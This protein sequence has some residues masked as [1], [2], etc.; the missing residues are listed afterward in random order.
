MDAF[1][2]QQ[3]ELL[4]KKNNQPV[5]S[6]G[7][8]VQGV[9]DNNQQPQ[10]YIAPWATPQ[11]AQPEQTDGG[12]VDAA[13]RG[14]KN[15]VLGT[16]GDQGKAFSYIA[17]TDGDIAQS[18]L[19]KAAQYGNGKTEEEQYTLE[20]RLMPWKN[21]FQYYTD[22]NGFIYEIANLGGSMATLAAESLIPIPGTGLMG[23]VVGKAV[24]NAVKS[25]AGKVIPATEA[26]NLAERAIIQN[27]KS[28]PLEILAN[29]GGAGDQWVEEHG[30]NREG[31]RQAVI[32]EALA[33]V[34]AALVDTALEV[35]G[36]LQ[37]LRGG[38]TG[39][40]AMGIA[41]SAIG[42]AYEEGYQNRA[43]KFAND[44]SSLLGVYDPTQWDADDWNAA[45]VGAMAGIPT[46][47]GAAGGY[48]NDRYRKRNS[49]QTPQENQEN[50]QA[51]QDTQQ[52]GYRPAIIAEGIE[53]ANLQNTI[54]EAVN[55][56]NALNQFAYDTF[57]KD[58]IVS[59]G[60]RSREHNAEVNGH[61]NSAHLYG[62]ALDLDLSNFTDEER[63]AIEERAQNLGFK[64]LYHDAGSGDH[65]HLEL[66]DGAVIN[67]KG[68][69]YTNPMQNSSLEG[70]ENAIEGDYVDEHLNALEQG[71]ALDTST[72]AGLNPTTQDL[73]E[74]LQ[75]SEQNPEAQDEL[76]GQVEEARK[77]YEKARQELLVAGRL[78]KAQN[79]PALKKEAA[80]KFSEIKAKYENLQNL[81]KNRYNTRYAPK[82]K[83][84]NKSTYQAP[85]ENQAAMPEFSGEYAR[86]IPNM[87][88][89]ELF[90]FAR[91]NPQLREQTTMEMRKRGL[92]DSNFNRAGELAPLGNRSV[93]RA[94]NMVEAEQEQEP[95]EYAGSNRAYMT[96]VN[97]SVD[98]RAGR[99]AANR[100]ERNPGGT[101]A[102]YPTQRLT[103]TQGIEEYQFQPEESA[104]NTRITNMVERRRQE[105]AA[106][107]NQITDGKAEYNPD[108]PSRF[109]DKGSS[110]RSK[111]DADRVAGI[112]DAEIVNDVKAAETKALK[113]G[114]SKATIGNIKRDPNKLLQLESKA[115]GGNENAAKAIA[116][117]KTEAIELAYAVKNGKGVAENEKSRTYDNQARED[118]KNQNSE[119]EQTEGNQGQGSESTENETDKVA[120]L[121]DGY[122]TQ[123][124]RD[125]QNADRDEFIVRPDGSLKFG[126]IT[127]EI[128]DLTN[129]ELEPGEIRVRVG[130]EAQGMIHA[131]KHESQIKDAG[132]NTAEE[133][134]EDT[135]KNIDEIYRRDPKPPKKKI[136][137]TV[138]NRKSDKNG[139]VSIGLALEK[140]E[141]GNY[142]AVI[143]A[144]PKTEK[145]LEK[146]I[147]KE[148]LVYRS[149]AIG[150][151]TTPNGSAVSD[152]AQNDVGLEQNRLPTSGISNVSKGSI[153]QAEEKSNN[154]KAF[155][156]SEKGT[157]EENQVVKPDVPYTFD[158]KTFNGKVKTEAVLVR[159]EGKPN[160]ETRTAMKAVGI[161]WNPKEK[162]WWTNV[163]N[164]K[165]MELV[166][167]W[168]YGKEE[169]K[170]N[171]DN[172]VR[173]DKFEEAVEALT[174]KVIEDE[175]KNGN[176]GLSEEKI[177]E[178]AKEL[179]PD[180]YN[181]E[182][183]ETM[184][185]E[186]M[187]KAEKDIAAN[188]EGVVEYKAETTNKE[189]ENNDAYSGNLQD[190]SG[191]QVSRVVQG[192]EGERNTGRVRGE[193][194]GRD[195]R[196]IQPGT[197]R[198]DAGEPGSGGRPSGEGKTGERTSGNGE[199]SSDSVSVR[200]GLNPEQKKNAKAKEHPGHNC[201]ISQEVIDGVKGEGFQAKTRFKNN[202]AAIR[203]IHKLETENR[204]ATPAEQ[205]VLAKYIGWGGLSEAFSKWT[206]DWQT[207]YKELQDMLQEGIITKEE[208]SSM[209]RSTTSAFYTPYGVVKG[210]W[211]M[212]ERFGFKGG[213]VLEPSMGTGNF[214]GIMPEKLRSKSSLQGVEYDKFTG[215]IAKQ[216]YQKANIEIAG[217][218]DVHN[219]ENF[220]DLIISNVP[221][222]EGKPRD[223]KYNKE[224]L[225]IHN[226]FF[227]KSVELTR[228]GGLIVF[229]TST[230]TMG[231]NGKQLRKL[232]GNKVDFIGAIRLPDNTFKGNAGTSVTSDLVIL[233]KREPNSAAGKNNNAWLEMVG[234]GVKVGWQEREAPI[235][236]YFKEHPEMLI[237]ETVSDRYG[238]GIV[239]S[240]KDKN[241]NELDPA[242]ELAAR[243][244]KLPANIY[245]PVKATTNTN[246]KEATETYLA[247]SKD[248][249]GSYKVKNG[250]VYTKTV[251]NK[252]VPLEERKQK[253]ALAYIGLRDIAK[254][255]LGA[256]IS[257]KTTDAELE[258]MRKELNKAYDDFVDK[259]GYLH[260]ST[261]QN[262][263]AQ[264]PEFGLIRGIERYD[265]V[266]E[267]NKV[268]SATAE[269]GA[270]FTQR[271]V[272]AL[273]T[274][275]KVDNV[276]DGLSV[277]LGQ[278][279]LVDIAY[280]SKLTGKSKA[281]V[282][283]ELKG[284]IYQDPVTQDYVTK[285]DYLSGNVR[286]KLEN[287]K[288]ANALE[289]K[290]KEN[291][292][293]LEKVVPKNLTKDDITVSLGSIWVPPSDFKDFAA[294]MLGCMPNN[295]DIQYN[296]A[297]GW[298]VALDDPYGR[299]KYSTANTDKWG[300]A[301][302][303][304]E[305]NTLN[306]K[307]FVDLLE[308][309]LNKKPTPKI[310]ISGSEGAVSKSGTLA[311]TG[312]IEEIK[313][314]FDNWIWSS[315]ERTERL[316]NYYNNHFNSYVPRVY[317]GD[318]LLAHLTDHGYSTA[319]PILRPHQ[320]DAVW[321]I[322]QGNTLLAHSVGAGKTWTMQTAAMEMKRLGIARKPMFVIPGHMLQQFENEFR[323]IYPNARLLSISTDT[324]PDV[325]GKMTAEKR[326]EKNALRQE[327]LSRIATED[328]DGIIISHDMFKRI[329]MSP[330][331]YAAFYQEEL[332]ELE[333]A[334]IAANADRQNKK[335]NI[336]KDLQAKKE[337]LEEKLKAS[338]NVEA[339]DI[340]IPFESLGIDQ[341]FVDEADLFKNLHFTTMMGNVS[342]LANS[343]AQRSTDMY[344]KTRYLTKNNSGRGVCFATGT[345]VS[346]SLA[347]EFTMLR[348]L[349][350]DRLQ[351]MGLQ[352]FDA[353]A[354]AFTKQVETAEVNP[355]GSGFRVV[356]KLKFSNGGD[357][358]RLFRSVADVK[359]P[360]DL[361]LKVPKLKNG[362]RTVVELP[363]NSAYDDF[364][365]KEIW[366]RAEAIRENKVEPEEDNMLKITS[367]QRL[368]S[369]DMRLVKPDLKSEDADAK[370]QAVADRVYQKF[371]DSNDIK[372]AQLVFCDLSTPK[373][374]SDKVT[375]TDAADEAEGKD[376]IV[377]Y[378]QILKKLV[379]KGI[380]KKQIAFAHDAKTKAQKEALFS[381]VR[382]GDIR[383]LIGSTTKMG[384]GTNC[385]Q[386]LVA[387]HH[388]DAPWRPRD[389][390]QR[391][392]R[393]LRQGNMNDEVE[394]FTYVTKGSF[395]ESMWGRIAYKSEVIE[396]ALSDDYSIREFDDI[397]PETLSYADIQA[398]ASGNPL[399][400]QQTIVN[401]EVT[402]LLNMK[403]AYENTQ[404]LQRR[405]IAELP[406]RIQ[407]YTEL[408]KIANDDV[409]STVNV[410]GDN[411]K[412]ELAGET[413]T[414]L[415]DA[416]EA[417]EK[418]AEGF[419]ETNFIPMG[420]I[421]HYS[422]EVKNIGKEYIGENNFKNKVEVKLVGK[423]VY[424]AEPSAQSIKYRAMHA[425]DN[426]A[427][428]YGRELEDNLK[429]LQDLQE[430]LK[431]P[432]PQ[433][434]ELDNKLELQQK[435]AAEIEAQTVDKNINKA[436]EPKEEYFNKALKKYPGIANSELIRKKFHDAIM[437]TM[438]IRA[439]SI[440]LATE[441]VESR[442]HEHPRLS[443]TLASGVTQEL[444]NE[445]T[446]SL[447]GKKI[448]SV[449]ELAEY[450]QVLRHP[451][452][453]K[454]HRIYVDKNGT[455]IDHDTVTSMMP[456]EVS[457]YKQ[458]ERG[459]TLQ[460]EML[461]KQKADRPEVAKVYYIHNHPST[462]TDPSEMD[463]QLTYKL[464]DAL[465]DKF[466]GHI[467]LD[468][469]KYAHIGYDKK[470]GM[471][472]SSEHR[473]PK[474][475][476]INYFAYPS[477]GSMN[478]VGK[479]IDGWAYTPT[480]AAWANKMDKEEGDVVAFLDSKYV[481]RAVVKLPT[482]INKLSAPA[483]NRYLRALARKNY[484]ATAIPITTSPEM[485][486]KYKTMVRLGSGLVDAMLVPPLKA[487]GSFDLS[488]KMKSAAFEAEE[489]PAKR[490]FFGR[491]SETKG[492]ANEAA[493][494]YPATRTPAMGDIFNNAEE[495]TL[496]GNIAKE[497]GV[498]GWLK[499][500]WKEVYIDWFDKN[501][502]LHALDMAIESGL[503]RKLNESEKV[504]NRNQTLPANTAG[505]AETLIEGSDAQITALNDALELKGTD[506]LSLVSMQKVLQTISKQVMD[507]VAPTFL[508]DNHFKN[509]VDAFGAYLG[510][511]RL[512][513]MYDV[514]KS[515]GVEYKLPKG[516]TEKQLRDFVKS[517]PKEFQAAATQYYLINRNLLKIMKQSGLISKEN[518]D[519]LTT[520]YKKYCPLMRDFTD[521]A[522]ADAFIGGLSNGGRGIANV[523]SMIKKISIEG[524]E[525]GVMNPLESTIKSIAVC[526]NRCER[527]NVARMAVD[528]AK[529][530]NG[531]L[532]D[533]IKMLP[534]PKGGNAQAD[535]KNCVFTVMIDGKK[536]AY[537]TTQE[538][539]SPIVGYNLPTAGFVYGI[540]KNAAS[541]LR[542]GATM[543]PSF[544]IRNVIR[545]TIFAGISSKNG[546]VPIVDTAR[547]AYE[548]WKNGQ[549]AAEF[550][551]AGVS[552]F[553]FFNNRETTYKDL[554]K[555]N[556]GKEFNKL[557][558]VDLIKAAAEWFED[559]SAFFEAATRMGEFVKARQKGQDIYAASRAARELTLDFSRSGV[560]GQNFN[561]YVPFFNA[562]LQG[563]DKMVR[564]MKE[565]FVGT[566]T[567]IA[568]YILLPS[569]LLWIANHDE[570]WYKEL[571]PKIKNAYWCFPGGFKIPKP[572]EAGVTFGSG[573]EALLDQAVN[574]DPRAMKNWAKEVW[575]VMSPNF[576][577]TA[578]LPIWEWWSNYSMFKNGPLVPRKLENLPGELQ[579]TN[580]TATLSKGIGKVT[581]LSPIKI[582]NLVRG[583]TGTMGMLLWQTGDFMEDKAAPEKRLSEYQ[584]FRDFAVNDQHLGRQVDEFYEILNA[585]TKQHN[586][587][588]KKGSP[589]KD[590][591]E[592]K[593][594]GTIISGLRKD[595]QKIEASKTMSP[596]RKRQLID[597]KRARIKA[598]A[599]KV[600]EKYGDKYL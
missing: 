177:K 416:T 18:L 513:E 57:G 139:V 352:N 375:E 227:K 101:A 572:Q 329:P 71:D 578:I 537:Q 187:E 135:L 202:V 405:E 173:K 433:Q 307:T 546:F 104:G 430:E 94:G 42:N 319:A 15:A 215:K 407:R 98:N 368:A 293:A 424:S 43:Q 55:G 348:Y 590:V 93:A 471:L 480:I 521:T 278:Q 600:V 223:L 420:K 570:D 444:V 77:E 13:A 380:P 246:A 62:Q 258:E 266:K 354:S 271:T 334:L 291:I 148:T 185:K 371:V 399:L 229:V 365:Q 274:V 519:I 141:D 372:G 446:V 571:D 3:N 245:K 32:K 28:K 360:K 512:L 65:L 207:Q 535:P 587:Y 25:L 589:T 370:I 447:V 595:V 257:D 332:D 583:Y 436:N 573:L 33:E 411:F 96:P 233:Q 29:A 282:I 442:R 19:D 49:Q 582:D 251:D 48:I 7:E 554:V 12:Y 38:G 279:G 456:D 569:L 470:E 596:E 150:A 599:K 149:P 120:A 304:A 171:F 421:G 388:V 522:A 563:G 50:V 508:A 409:K 525:R 474:D 161:R 102:E 217:F 17:G 547:G 145:K 31:A 362:K 103:G 216:L 222:G 116:M 443:K 24:P 377:V 191:E 214:F 322:M 256:Q 330:E 294:H 244:E 539:Y 128:S 558:P 343:D 567:K 243:I 464:H 593:K 331:Q 404:R 60:T 301:S 310:T 328:W 408:A 142:Y 540:A 505:A 477:K 225:K 327:T 110:Y 218:E 221:F 111:E 413:Y 121:K 119:P 58:I 255:I 268:V 536:V 490:T 483:L 549:Y 478:P 112:Q 69:D 106:K 8:P 502:P 52:Q 138:V 37:A 462:V 406:A 592:I 11:Q 431:K 34:P 594:F 125:L 97:N 346:N 445:G 26:R 475:K 457:V 277:S 515:A 113:A 188:N 23:K 232:I 529:Q 87:T 264:D 153:A 333:N 340:V 176:M 73:N 305:G 14:F 559:K 561:Q 507:K 160:E 367:E 140:G 280:I 200:A 107:R 518:Y 165:G 147:K 208:Y 231:K 158:R 70:A 287:A 387:L 30:G 180:A 35:R 105:Q 520:K 130:Y 338:A 9:I 47:V 403:A 448:K 90:G 564:L 81:L 363:K 196:D 157:T 270:I 580:H 523:S 186:A 552:S 544:I 155:N 316:V 381:K 276:I 284:Q 44:Q 550:K 5:N 253:R 95:M 395:D 295:I 410:D 190:V 182:K 576:I 441:D 335:N 203:L 378:E 40:R 88:D 528:Y 309:V 312:K 210:I 394:I 123:S 555:M 224:G 249:I 345:P 152:S 545:D 54:P 494:A 485:Y 386:R 514:A 428:Y 438:N 144:L 366:P 532:D 127:K 597:N 499:A 10:Y 361:N 154:Q 581:G 321:R 296:P 426:T 195:V 174:S 577:P 242:K 193:E 553:N 241:G 262:A 167:Q 74:A 189:G 275:T 323:V 412:M 496:K 452:Y 281:D 396:Q 114:V 82:Q 286:E 219:P 568:E 524:S 267:G 199:G 588:G 175:K 83:Q 122:K 22:P 586:G 235:N 59:G 76:A 146:G 393:I 460:S 206:R 359:R 517:A 41:K 397:G 162:A 527:N 538:L 117:V 300:T 543:S 133:F 299:V 459:N 205:E 259:F 489:T 303:D 64:T 465:G 170:P 308:I 85:K 298:R 194:T 75:N 379:A 349:A 417:F 288:Q 500:K 451:G 463:V 562:C 509:W 53:D 156:S 565:D 184:A 382:N 302:K 220:Y 45:S 272:N 72:L 373:G 80:A 27:A 164:K 6:L 472:Y 341:L 491:T 79:N 213:R 63:A 598:V 143:T 557:N 179:F 250:K 511:E 325:G 317:N 209:E 234:S 320:T 497:G 506:R 100:G 392:G 297:I 39:G 495:S 36:G 419:N 439:E 118:S 423:G 211:N 391:E 183:L 455:I 86:I 324:L 526:M 261:N 458:D 450:A 398:V 124:G 4:K 498:K 109:R 108:R 337:K 425:A 313:K 247:D 493:T 159:F 178:K 466:G 315:K 453:E 551:A 534:T 434:K 21:G 129:G 260:N 575:G 181:D 358:M 151:T 486:E 389:I 68:I 400:A 226:Y 533:V 503:G 137:Y 402:K 369:L 115:K 290:Y 289:G 492:V 488:G 67:A 66:P 292:A 579:Y 78:A 306:S 2:L 401:S 228:P 541:M 385:Q 548:L 364:L 356:K 126:E 414:T 566:S 355:S 432:F 163:N 339:K 198:T 504:Y 415:K 461:Y 468:T 482:D 192:N 383:V 311:A 347:E 542:T 473:I 584:F 384:A 239:Q 591:Q 204:L 236:E 326:N 263:L 169:A 531:A 136:S 318:H 376:G 374:Q 131:K 530:A 134:I 501:D 238:N 454:F 172:V 56:V 132:Y 351:E 89:A 556:G 560:K 344:I 314:E 16:L 435:I 422:I 248:R 237:G 487:N 61:P 429:R 484:A 51:E 342:G 283:K 99:N 1:S 418:L 201:T 476:Q 46:A 20:D 92:T 437:S 230:G 467:I 254:K 350:Y 197:Q 336:V 166:E 479:K 585:A 269:K 357:L 574:N 481:C 285:D 440:K 252:L 510:S 240:G 91:R 469:T 265:E 84:E 273:S 353:W 212:V 168:G 390:E 449:K 427:T 516:V